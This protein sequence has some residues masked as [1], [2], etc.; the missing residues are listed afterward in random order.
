MIY[1]GQGFKNIKT[2]VHERNREN[3]CRRRRCAKHF[4]NF[5]TILTNHEKYH[6]AGFFPI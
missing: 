3:G 2:M 5:A 1:K 6:N 4:H